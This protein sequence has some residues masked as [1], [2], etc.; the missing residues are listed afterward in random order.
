MQGH[1][2]QTKK[3]FQTGA[4][5]P[6]WHQPALACFLLVKMVAKVFH[7]MMDM[8]SD[9]FCPSSNWVSV[10]VLQSYVHL[11]EALSEEKLGW[12]LVAMQHNKFFY[13]SQEQKQVNELTKG[14]LGKKISVD[15]VN[16]CTTDT[17]PLVEQGIWEG[18]SHLRSSS[19]LLLVTLAA[20]GWAFNF[21][22]IISTICGYDGCCIVHW[23]CWGTKEW[24]VA[25]QVVIVKGSK[26]CQYEY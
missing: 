5:W 19:I 14:L 18:I 20:A 26:T 1:P 21:W 2:I 15:V 17:N 7:G 4:H 24:D 11:R 22:R 6:E 13:Q 3:C 16:N 8:Q 10:M 25:R 12:E 23:Q 9:G